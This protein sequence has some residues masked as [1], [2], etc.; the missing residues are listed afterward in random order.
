MLFVTIKDFKEFDVFKHF[1][2]TLEKGGFVLNIKT[3]RYETV[4]GKGADTN[5]FA[6]D[7]KIKLSNGDNNED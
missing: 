5:K 4:E 7:I 2:E 3:G 1:C 6:G